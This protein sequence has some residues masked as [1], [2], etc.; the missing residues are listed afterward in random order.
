MRIKYPR[1]GQLRLL[2][3]DRDN[4][5][6][7]VETDSNEY[8]NITG[9]AS[10]YDFSEY[11]LDH[12]RYDSSNRKALG[13]FKDKLNPLPMRGFVGLRPKCYAF[14]RNGKVSGNVPPSH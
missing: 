14:L 13:F 4:L 8:S 9:A 1:A 6:Y 2:F 5:A 10:L 12:P 3:T 11:P 7:A